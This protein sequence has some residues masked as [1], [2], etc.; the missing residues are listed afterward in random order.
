MNNN[1][2]KITETLNNCLILVCLLIGTPFIPSKLNNNIYYYQIINVIIT[3]F[4]F[5]IYPNAIIIKLTNYDMM[6]I[7]FNICISFISYC[8]FINI[9]E[10]SLYETTSIYDINPYEVFCM[11]PLWLLLGEFIFF[12]V[13]LLL[14]NANIYKYIHKV[15][16]KFKITSSF[17]S[18]YAHPIDNLS[19]I[20][21]V[22]FPVMLT[23][24]YGYIISV[25]TISVFMSLVTT[26][27]ISSH[28]TF[29]I[30]NNIL[31]TGHLLHH[32]KFNVNYGNFS[33][34]DYIYVKYF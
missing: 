3:F 21:I 29:N 27:F 30:N 34:F 19:I 31:G 4:I 17:T 7:F 24:Y 2:I 23:T 11:V 22:L 20:W 32:N 16:H 26:T 6:L 13:H 25:T 1:T 18:F 28:S 15:H 12:S 10:N 8:V 14:H 33:I 9:I 5:N